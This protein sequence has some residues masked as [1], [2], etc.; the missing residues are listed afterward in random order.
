MKLTNRQV[1]R[2]RCWKEGECYIDTSRPRK[3]GDDLP[4]LPKVCFAIVAEIARGRK[5]ARGKL[6]AATQAIQLILEVLDGVRT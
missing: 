6:K 2:I 4:M 3:P 1:R 5:T